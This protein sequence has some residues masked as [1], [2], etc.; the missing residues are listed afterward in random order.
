MTQLLEAE[1][2][3][4]VL[5][6]GLDPLWVGESNWQVTIAR[7]LHGCTERVG[8]SQEAETERKTKMQMNFRTWL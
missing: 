4:L 5:L 3:S 8:T 7:H 1:L 6:G 2:L